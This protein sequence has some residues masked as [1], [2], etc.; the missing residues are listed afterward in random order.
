[1]AGEE[2]DDDMMAWMAEAAAERARA[3]RETL[4]SPTIAA[5]E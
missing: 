4:A 5:S 2:G 1:M 3:M